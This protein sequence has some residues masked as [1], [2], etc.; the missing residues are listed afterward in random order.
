M[1]PEELSAAR[2]YIMKNEGRRAEV[3]F[4][5]LGIPTI[6]VGFNLLRSDAREKIGALD[7]DHDRLLGREQVLS[8]EQIEALFAADVC[9]AMRAAASLV[10]GWSA[11]A[12]ARKTALTDMAFNLGAAGLAKF[13]RLIAAVNREQWDVAA[14]EIVNSRYARQVGPRARRNALAIRLGDMAEETCE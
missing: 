2:R 4:D 6:G 12:V 11:L 9:T 8:D 13:S 3:Y 14:A 1:T 5:S 7:L 10:P